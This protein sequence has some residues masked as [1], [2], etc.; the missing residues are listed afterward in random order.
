MKLL[1]RWLINAV[2]LWIVTRLD[3]GVSVPN[4]KWALLAAL[5][6]GLV[7]ATLGL[8]LKVVTFPLTILTFGIFLIL[9]NAAMLQFASW[10][11]WPDFRVHGWASAI[12]GAIL[13][14]VVST[15]L[16]WLVGDKRRRD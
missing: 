9:I 1:V 8:F 11:L 16:H 5:V 3:I 2:S 13:L 10:L 15:I 4:F 6:I 7:N 14:S 12:I